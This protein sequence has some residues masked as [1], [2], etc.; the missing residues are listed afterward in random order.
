[1]SDVETCG[2]CR[3]FRPLYGGDKGQCRRRCPATVLDTGLGVWPGVMRGLSACGDFKPRK[4]QKQGKER[5]R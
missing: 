1:M 2:G 4:D 5:G 3:F